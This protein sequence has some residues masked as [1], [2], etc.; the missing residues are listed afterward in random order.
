M[1]VLRQT[2]T[3]CVS[4]PAKPKYHPEFFINC[5][6]L[7]CFY[8]V[9]FA[10]VVFFFASSSRWFTLYSKRLSSM[11]GILE[12]AS[13]G[14]VGRKVCCPFD[15]FWVSLHLSGP[16]KQYLK[17]FQNCGANILPN[18][19][20]D[21]SLHFPSSVLFSPTHSCA[22]FSHTCWLMSWRQIS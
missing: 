1:F 19:D 12:L 22:D 3:N 6:L 4:N 10:F 17:T 8:F 16:G 13:D 2:N 15:H 21:W 7:I 5:L 18:C 11:L 20:P 14:A 9:V